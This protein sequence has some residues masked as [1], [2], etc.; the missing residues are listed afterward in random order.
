MAQT[1]GIGPE[2]LIWHRL[3]LWTELVMFSSLRSPVRSAASIG[4]SCCVAQ[5]RHQHPVPVSPHLVA[6]QKSSAW[7]AA[8]KQ[9][10]NRWYLVVP[11]KQNK[12]GPTDDLLQLQHL[13]LL[14]Q[15]LLM[16]ELRQLLPALRHLAIL[17]CSWLSKGGSSTHRLGSHGITSCHNPTGVLPEPWW[18][19]MRRSKGFPMFQ[20]DPLPPSSVLLAVAAPTPSRSTGRM[21][22]RGLSR[23]FVL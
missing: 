9:I 16:S 8:Y 3:L 1:Q 19:S 22:T 6:S 5:Q 15:Q 2:E 12:T 13:C 7:M 17:W 23:H 4:H 14:Q 11:L 10:Q 20:W 18:I 21:A